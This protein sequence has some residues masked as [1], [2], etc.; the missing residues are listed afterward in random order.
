MRAM[1]IMNVS[2]L[3]TSMSTTTHRTADELFQNPPNHRWELV[4]GELRIM[5]PAGAKHGWVLVNIAGFLHDFVKR[6]KL[7]YV[8]GAETG[9]CIERDPDTVR[10]P[11]VAFVK[12]ERVE[13]DLPDEF[14]PGAPDL[15]VEVLSLDDSASAVQEKSKNWLRCGCHEVWLVDPR[16]KTASRYTLENGSVFT[17]SGDELTADVLPGFTLMV[18]EIFA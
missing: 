17:R 2:Q 9:F 5:S 7:G 16:R 12:T 8:F 11:D 3:D 6:N 10:A 4:R 1:R 13:G 15:A 14:F 18:A